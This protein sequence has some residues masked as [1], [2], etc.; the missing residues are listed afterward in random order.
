[1]GLSLA[2]KTEPA[3]GTDPDLDWLRG[4]T[5]VH[6]I[7]VG[8]TDPGAS[9]MAILTE[10]GRTPGEIRTLTL[11]PTQGE[12]FEAVLQVTGLNSEDARDLVGRI[13][14]YPGAV[15]AAIEHVLIR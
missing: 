11:K 14:M 15:S 2:V 1:M 12:H 10:L 6:K 4:R 3:S 8:L 5:I 7:V 13:A 9:A